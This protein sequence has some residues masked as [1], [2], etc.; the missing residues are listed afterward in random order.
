MYSSEVK[1]HD[2]SERSISDAEEIEPIQTVPLKI[3]QSLSLEIEATAQ[4]IIDFR[5]SIIVSITLF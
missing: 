2:T 5:Q 3:F 4:S 1:Q